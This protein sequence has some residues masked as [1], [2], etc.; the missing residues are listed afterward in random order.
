MLFHIKLF[1]TH[2]SFNSR[3]RAMHGDSEVSIFSEYFWNGDFPVALVSLVK[4][5]HFL[6]FFFDENSNQFLALF[7]NRL[8]SDWSQ[9][10]ELFRW[11]RVM[12]WSIETQNSSENFNST[13]RDFRSQQ[14]RNALKCIS[15]VLYPTSLVAVDYCRWRKHACNNSP[16]F[17][18]SLLQPL[19]YNVHSAT[20]VTQ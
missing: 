13:C 2:F 4:F 6:H 8:H 18:L 19:T 17:S 20:R 1:F 5:S 15:R 12:N 16:P 11:W 7:S 10:F 9:K 14:V 3:M